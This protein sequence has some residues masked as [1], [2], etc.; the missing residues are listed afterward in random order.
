M[1]RCRIQGAGIALLAIALGASAHAADPIEQAVGTAI[2]NF[3]AVSSGAV[4]RGARPDDVGIDTLARAGVRTIIDLQGGDKILGI[5]TEAGE[6]SNDIRMEGL[7][8]QA[9]GM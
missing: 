5:P 9:D 1:N 2:R 3:H 7:R 6:S 4:Y 8:A